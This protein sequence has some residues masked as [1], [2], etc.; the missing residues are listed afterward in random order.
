M[1]VTAQTIQL[2]RGEA[3]GMCAI[4]SW[5]GNRLRSIQINDLAMLAVKVYGSDQ[6]G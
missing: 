3:A 6:R 4:V 2:I 5:P 1:L